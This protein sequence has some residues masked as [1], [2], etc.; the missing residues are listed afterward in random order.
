MGV[1]KINAPWGFKFDIET[2]KQIEV[3]VDKFDTSP[4]PE[5]TVRVV[6]MDEPIC[7]IYNK[8]RDFPNC[9]TYVLTFLQEVLDNNPK[10]HF[11]R[12]IYAWVDCNKHYEKKFCVSTVVG[13]KYNPKFSGYSIRHKLLDRINEVKIPKNFYVSHDYK[14]WMANGKDI[15]V[16]GELQNDKEKMFDCMYHIA[17][18]NTSIDNYF[19]EKIIDCFLTKTIPLH[20]GTPNLG[21]FFNMDAVYNIQNVDEIISVCNTL[22]PELYYSKLDAIEDNYNRALAYRDYVEP[23]KNTIINLL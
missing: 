5:N 21:E 20:Y 7:C 23:L 16:L 19:S 10:A 9:Y 22:T 11:F 6:V 17:I 13:W 8:V 2:D 18:E 4:I 12:G 14:P 1:V 15:F 3:L